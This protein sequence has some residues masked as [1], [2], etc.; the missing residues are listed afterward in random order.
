[1]GV[2]FKGDF[3]RENTA[4]FFSLSF[5]RW[6]LFFNILSPFTFQYASHSAVS[7]SILFYLENIHM[8]FELFL[9]KVL[10]I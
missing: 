7:H 3:E 9:G 2:Q 4:V 1:M 5:R 6:T 10:T 8:A